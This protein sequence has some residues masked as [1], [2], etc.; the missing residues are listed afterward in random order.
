[1]PETRE[2]P[3]PSHGKHG[4]PL[5]QVIARYEDG[6]EERIGHQDIETWLATPASD[7][8]EVREHD[9]NPDDCPTYYD[10]CNCTVKNLLALLS[11]TP[12]VEGEA[13]QE[14]AAWLV[15]YLDH[16]SDMESKVCRRRREAEWHASGP[17]PA[18]IVPLYRGADVPAPDSQITAAKVV[19]WLRARPGASYLATIQDVDAAVEALAALRSAPSGEGEEDLLEAAMQGVLVA[20]ALE[21]L[22]DRL[23]MSAKDRKSFGAEL[24][25][26]MEELEPV[27][28]AID[29]ARLRADGG[30]E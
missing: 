2:R 14:P 27:R 11:G 13:T 18:R 9:D 25:E 16:G 8:G 4:G 26:V 1:M 17:L 22:Y 30:G 12:Q 15:D 28:A 29:A 23:K 19:A 21:G 5:V 3:I 10:G 7:G 6:T 24:A 20:E